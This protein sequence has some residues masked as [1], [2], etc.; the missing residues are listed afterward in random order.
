MNFRTDEFNDLLLELNVRSAL[1]RCGHCKKLA[2]EWEKAAVALKGDKSAGVPITLAA[3]D[4]TVEKSLGEKFEVQGFPTIKIFENGSDSPSNY[5]GPR[6]ANGFIP[7]P[8]P[9]KR[10]M[11]GSTLHDHTECA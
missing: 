3:V 2:P 11:Q 10:A 5:E 6:E 1:F 9:I 4:A 7:L 8:I